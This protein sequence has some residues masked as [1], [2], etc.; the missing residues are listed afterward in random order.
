M[1]GY[2]ASEAELGSKFRLQTLV[3]VTNGPLALDGAAGD[4]QASHRSAEAVYAQVQL[5]AS[6]LL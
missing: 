3:S 5:G 4:A 6:R 1:Q 2:R